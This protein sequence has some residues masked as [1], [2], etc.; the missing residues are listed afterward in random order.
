[1]MWKQFKIT[2]FITFAH[3]KA[4]H[5]SL[6]IKGI[7][8]IQ[9]H[10]YSPK[11]QVDLFWIIC[12]NFKEDIDKKVIL[13]DIL[14]FVEKRVRGLPTLPTYPLDTRKAGGIILANMHKPSGNTLEGNVLPT[15]E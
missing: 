13:M 8:H 4:K 11:H 9:F 2:S 5:S 6:Y 12:P 10:E 7:L 14:V 3:T 15:D 1:M